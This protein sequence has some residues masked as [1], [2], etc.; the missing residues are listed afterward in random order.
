MEKPVLVVLAAGMGSRYGGLKQIDSVGPHG[1]SIL[2]YSVYDARRAGFEKVVFIIKHAIEDDF[3]AAVGARISR[4]MEVSYAYQELDD[5]PAGFTVPEGRKKPWGT[6]HAVLAAR[7]LI[8]GPF[9]VVNADDYY[10]PQAFKEI[11]GYLTSHEDAPDCYQYAMVAYRL[12][13]TLSESGSV[14]RGVCEVDGDGYLKRVVERTCIERDGS[15]GRFTEDG[16]GTWTHLDGDTPVSMNI[17]GFQES[18]I[19]ESQRRFSAFL[20]SALRENPE[21]AE[22]FLPLPVS[23]LVG[24]G[25]AKVKVLHSPDRWFGVTYKEDKPLV[26]SSL[27]G[28]VSEGLYP[29]NLWGV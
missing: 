27:A 8:H 12:G 11:Y 6:T 1:Q 4:G 2:D 9:A 13:N 16:G 22:F 3:K 10:G 25:R 21:K 28:K 14:A 7:E 20:D 23:A 17:W 19:H 15:G 18:F 5:L 26:V 24:E 29:E